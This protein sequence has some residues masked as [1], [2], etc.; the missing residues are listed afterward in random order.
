M[1]HPLAHTSR[2]TPL[3]SPFHWS[4]CGSVFTFASLAPPITLGLAACL[5]SEK[6]YGCFADAS[7]LWPV[8]FD[9][10]TVA[11]ILSPLASRLPPARVVYDPWICEPIV[12]Q[13][14][15]G[16]LD[17]DGYVHEPLEFERVR[18]KPSVQEME[19]S[20]ILFRRFVEQG[21]VLHPR[22]AVLSE[23]V[24]SCQVF[25]NTNGCRPDFPWETPQ[26]CWELAV[27][28]ILAVGGR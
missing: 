24:L 9:R 8:C 26:V 4:A 7:R 14:A 18:V 5:W 10:L 3:I 16:V 17:L 25:T 15:A 12:N 13:L 6:V 11:E 23:S 1:A 20:V 21:S 28:A 22:H 19:K 2:P 27:A